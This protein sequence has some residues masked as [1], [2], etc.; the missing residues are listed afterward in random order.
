MWGVVV[1]F[2]PT[3]VGPDLVTWPRLPFAVVV[4]AV[5]F[6]AVGFVDVRVELRPSTKLIYQLVAAS[7][8]TAPGWGCNL[9]GVHYLDQ[10]ATI[11]WLVLCVNV[12]DLSGRSSP[13]ALP[14][15]PQRA[16]VSMLGPPPTF[17]TTPRRFSSTCATRST[18]RSD[19]SMR[20]GSGAV[21][22][23][24]GRTRLWRRCRAFPAGLRPS[25]GS[26]VLLSSG[27]GR[28][29]CTRCRGR[30]PRPSPAT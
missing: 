28:A 26:P 24:I 20:P 15:L 16:R 9:I 18:C 3:T 5:A 14:E 6:F 4:G 23:R 2:G 1:M 19:R 27:N 21:G 29:G 12:L 8:V 11:A 7:A 22:T 10:L 17:R 25:V 30:C 13:S